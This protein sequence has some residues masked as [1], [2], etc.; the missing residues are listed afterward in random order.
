MHTF[1]YFV[2]YVALRSA[3]YALNIDGNMHIF[4]A[5]SI[6][7]QWLEGSKTIC[8]PEEDMEL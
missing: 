2:K 4:Y 3:V 6:K 1:K 7:T 8:P 5:F